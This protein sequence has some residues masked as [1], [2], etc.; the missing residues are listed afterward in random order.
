MQTKYK[1]SCLHTFFFHFLLLQKPSKLQY[2]HILP[3]DKNITCNSD[4]VSVELHV[5]NTARLFVAAEGA[6][7]EGELGEGD[8]SRALPEPHEAG[9]PRVASGA[10]QRFMEAGRSAGTAGRPCPGLRRQKAL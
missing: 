10:W 1:R 9:P 4:R 3:Y 7:E 8:F 2:I 6:R 5:G